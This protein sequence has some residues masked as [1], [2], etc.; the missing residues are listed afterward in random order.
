MKQTLTV[1]A[2]DGKVITRKT[3]KNYTHAL[4]AHYRQ[5]WGAI[6]FCGSRQLAERQYKKHLAW[7]SRDGIEMT[8]AEVAR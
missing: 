5:G 4:L 1:T 2:P 3:E 7:T 8:I 6:A